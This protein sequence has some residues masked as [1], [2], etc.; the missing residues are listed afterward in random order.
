MAMTRTAKFTFR[1]V[2]LAEN[3]PNTSPMTATGITNQLSNPS[4]GINAT[5]AAMRATI[6]MRVEIMFMALLD[7]QAVSRVG[8]NAWTRN[9]APATGLRKSVI[10]TKSK[11]HANVLR[12]ENIHREDIML[13]RSLLPAAAIAAVCAGPAFAQTELQ[14]WHAMSTVNA[15]LDQT[16]NNGGGAGRGGSGFLHRCDEW[17]FCL[18]AARMVAE[19]ERR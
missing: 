17:S 8:R 1:P 19:Q 13:N 16:L 4:K 7:A 14:W 18:T 12:N 2:V 5:S 11:L 3:R 9:P 15:V 6:P 10:E